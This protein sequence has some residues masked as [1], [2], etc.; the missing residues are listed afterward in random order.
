MATFTR[1]FSAPGLASGLGAA[2]EYEVRST[3]DTTVLVSRRNTGVAEVLGSGAYRVAIPSFNTAWAG[4]IRW[5][6]ASGTVL[7]AYEEFQAA[8]AALAAGDVDGYTLEESLRVILA[9]AAGRLSG[10]ETD[11]VAIW[12][13]DGSKPRIEAAVDRLGNRVTVTLDV[14]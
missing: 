13:A 11:E 1:P 8:G 4:F 12:A 9:S 14:S 6:T 2:L 3:D 7:E 5:T 10:A